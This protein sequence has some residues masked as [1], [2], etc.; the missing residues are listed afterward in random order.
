[1]QISVAVDT[2]GALSRRILAIGAFS[3]TVKM[4]DFAFQKAFWNGSTIF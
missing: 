2:S 1:M 3:A 4:V